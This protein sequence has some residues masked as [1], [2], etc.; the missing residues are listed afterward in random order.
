MNSQEFADDYPDRCA[1]C[2]NPLHTDA[3]LCPK[4]GNPTTGI[5]TLRRKFQFTAG[6]N[7]LVALLF[8][9][10]VFAVAYRS[11]EAGELMQTYAAFVGLPFTVGVLTTY[12]VRPQSGLGATLKV[13]T[14]MLCLVSVLL[15]EGMV[16]IL[17]AAPMFYVVAIIGYGVVASIS[18]FF[19]PRGPG[20]S[21]I[22]LVLTALPYL[23]GVLAS[24][25]HDIANAR[26]MTV[27]NSLFVAAPPS[28]V[29]S[30]LHQGEL[31]S[32]QFPLFLRLGFPLPTQLERSENGTARLTFDPGSEPWPGANVIVSRETSD[33]ARQSLTFVIQEDGTKLS[34]WLTFRHT[35]FAV[36]SA[37][38]GSRIR[39]TTTWTQ[40][41]QPGLYWNSLQSFAMTQMHQYALSHIKELSEA[42]Q[43]ADSG[44]A[45]KP[46]HEEQK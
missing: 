18:K 40:R 14:V 34:R 26:T 1:W 11:I 33:K 15:G 42:S 46:P 8:V 45:K 44:T 3:K 23:W 35:Q 27:K 22:L 19:G 38:G 30:T 31:V 25:P 2:E 17:M 20:K 12:L 7:I 9:T 16:C 6:N 24:N 43:V 36:D 32:T 13:T 4:C 10:A 21:M 39:Q 28:T 5:T 41:M 37:E 29:W